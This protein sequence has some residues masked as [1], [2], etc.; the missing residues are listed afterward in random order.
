MDVTT[1]PNTTSSVELSLQR[2]TTNVSKA[3]ETISRPNNTNNNNLAT[4]TTKANGIKENN[5]SNLT[6]VNITSSTPLSGCE[7]MC[8]ERDLNVSPA[9]LNTE[10]SMEIYYSRHFI[11]NVY[12]FI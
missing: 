4:K 5:N 6:S 2:P 12:F 10:V 8:V 3:L 11:K 1:I 9:L 7:G